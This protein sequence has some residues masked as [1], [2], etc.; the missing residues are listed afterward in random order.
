MLPHR[1]CD[2]VGCERPLQLAGMGHIAGLDLAT[3]VTRAGG[4]G[5]IAMPMVPAP[6]LAGILDDLTRRVSGPVGVNFLVPFL[7]PDCVPVAAER[8]RVLEWFYDTPDPA[9]VEAAHR[10]GALAGWQVGS[11]AEARQ[12]VDAGC[13]YVVLQGVEAGGHVRSRESLWQL[14]DQA[15]AGLGVP[16]VAA[17]GLGSPAAVAAAFAAGADAVR[18]GTRFVAAT[19]ADAHPDYVAALFDATAA[20][21]ELTT[22]FGTMW[23][24]APHRVLR[25]S[26]ARASESEDESVG[27]I[28]LVGD[29]IPV[30]RLSPI[31][32]TRGFAGDVGA[33]PLY[34]GHSVDAVVRP[35]PAAEIVAELLD[36][37]VEILAGRNAQPAGRMSTARAMS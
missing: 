24:D 36:G 32:A 3:A 15:R 10:G 27:E 20:D 37:A 16:V 17:G 7:E 12:A 4:L 1:F 14:L 23:P 22:A 6:A 18:V 13:D 11:L 31:A 35:Q 29:T 30:P 19:E 26:I 5:M 28:T 2:L 33:M 34:A 21:T 25:S 9:L 8:V